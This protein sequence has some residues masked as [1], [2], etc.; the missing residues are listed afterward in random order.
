M[1]GKEKWSEV[2][3]FPAELHVDYGNDMILILSFDESVRYEGM[4][5][6]CKF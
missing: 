3:T 2:S 5:G 4:D 6:F 1:E